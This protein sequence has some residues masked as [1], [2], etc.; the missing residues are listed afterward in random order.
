MSD[1]QG[2]PPG[3]LTLVLRAVFVPDGY[4]PP[5]GFIANPYALRFRA[6]Y[7]PETGILTCEETSGGVVSGLAAKW[8]PED[9]PGDNPFADPFE[10]SDRGPDDDGPAW[11]WGLPLEPLTGD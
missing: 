4:D 10:P 11:T 1:F 9:A 7:D 6:T 5:V 8:R 2:A 3:P